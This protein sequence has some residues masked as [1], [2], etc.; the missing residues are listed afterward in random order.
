ML[1]QM[2]K[3]LDDERLNSVY[4]AR[5]RDRESV[6]TN[7][8]KQLEMLSSNDAIMTKVLYRRCYFR[9]RGMYAMP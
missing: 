4:D 6:V 3:G 2:K 8:R 5:A 9:S 1:T 7:V